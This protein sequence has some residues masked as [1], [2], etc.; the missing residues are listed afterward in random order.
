MNPLVS[1]ILT[2][3]NDA[4]NVVNA[5]NSIKTQTLNNWQ[6][7]IVDD[8]ST[9]NSYMLIEKA[10]ENDKRILLLKNDKNSGMFISR[11]IAIQK[12][13]AKYI[14]FI[15]SDD[16]MHPE[17]LYLQCAFLEKYR[18]FVCTISK[19]ERI[20]KGVNFGEITMMFRKSIINEMGYFDSV[21]FA[22]DSEF[23]QRL[24]LKYPSRVKKINK[25]LYYAMNRPNSLTT[26]SDTGDRQI[27]DLYVQRYTE[28]HNNGNL[29]MS[30]PLV[31]RPFV[32]PSSLM[33]P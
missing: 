27:R 13:T 5:I 7:I 9:D 28:W 33:D 25:I 4:D 24:N 26:S 12:S 11:N 6:L 14:T 20:G 22:A 10:K 32:L 15:D 16:R 8:A 3:Y 1:V 19:Y 2:V 18:F 21:R 30:F 31:T 23:L 17:K 29:F